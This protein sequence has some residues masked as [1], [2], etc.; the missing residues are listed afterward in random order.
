MYISG[1]RV[2]LQREFRRCIVKALVSHASNQR[3]RGRQPLGALQLTRLV[4]RHFLGI[5]KNEE[6]KTLSRMCVVCNEALRQVYEA[7]EETGRKKKRFG[8]STTLQCEECNVA[9]CV[10]PCNRIYHTCKDYVAAYIREM[11]Q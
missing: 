5:I 1:E 2:M 3:N 8:H 10:S 11:Q 7:E 6:G 9:L 4:D